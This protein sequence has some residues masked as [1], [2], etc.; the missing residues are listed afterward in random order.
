MKYLLLFI[1]CFSVS[2][3]KKP[4]I[5]F[6][7]TDQHFADAMSHVIGDE[8]IK[9]PNLDRLA[10]SGVRF[11]KAYACNPLCIPARNSIFTGYYPFET[12]IQSNSNK[13]APKNHMTMMGDRK[14]VV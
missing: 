5:L 14:S 6:I 4:N 8:H 2:A 9:T 1:L 10:N 11:T 7:L 12:G 13:Q 3:E